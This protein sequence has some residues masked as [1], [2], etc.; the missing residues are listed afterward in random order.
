MKDTDKSKAFR[1]EREMHPRIVLKAQFT[2]TIVELKP[3]FSN[4]FLSTCCYHSTPPKA[5]LIHFTEQSS[6]TGFCPLSERPG[7]R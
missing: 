4:H 3:F 1:L 6:E 2:C 7:E 5:L